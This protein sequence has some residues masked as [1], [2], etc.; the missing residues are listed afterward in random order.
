MSSPLEAIQI[1]AAAELALRQR[2]GKFTRYANDPI[3]FIEH[4]LGEWL[5]DEQ[6]V[7][8]LSVRDSRETNVQ[9]SHGVGKS[10]LASRLAIWWILCVNGLVITT[11]PTK[12]QVEKILW[13]NIRKLHQRLN[14]PGTCGQMFLTVTEQAKGFGFTADATSSNAFQG[15]HDDRLLVIEDESCGISEEID[16]GASSCATGA[17]NRLLRIGN[18]VTTNTPFQRACARK[19]LRIPVWTHPNV[20]WAYN[21]HD[22]GVHRL[23]PEVAAAILDE[24]GE[25]KDQSA[26]SDW[27]PRDRI[28]GAVSVSWIEDVRAKK[29]EKSAFWQSRVEGLFVIDSESSIVPRSWFAA[30]RARYDADPA[31]W[32]EMAAKHP[33]RHGLDVGDGGDDHAWARW[34]GAV[35]YAVETH[36][37][38]GDREDVT[39]AAGIAAKKLTEHPGSIAVDRVGVGAGALAILL[40]NGHEADGVAWGESADDPS[41]FIN[42]KAEDFWELREAF[43]TGEIAIAPLGDI[44]DMVA[45]DLAGI[46]YEETSTE[47]IRIEDKVKKTKKRL[48]RSPNAGDATVLGFKK[49]ERGVWGVSTAS[50]SY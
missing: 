23:K 1:R 39:R 37:T 9:A 48:H 6:K 2:R 35:L 46:Y 24:A 16:D 42:C 28:D 45:E 10:H 40:E 44:E 18:P 19:H 47:K 7:I 30:A 25:V 4:E 26:W 3:G 15:I 49:R 36:G 12:R 32:D 13:S 11:A 22:D 17:N 21:L 50:Y 8:C 38:Q 29:G 27:C 43:R 20:A 31:K 5:T 34:Q 14:L 41:Q 33:S